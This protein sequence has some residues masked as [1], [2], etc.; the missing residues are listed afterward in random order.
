MWGGVCVLVHDDGVNFGIL[1]KKNEEIGKF[2]LAFD[3][4]ETKFDLKQLIAQVEEG[5]LEQPD[6]IK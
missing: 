4:S 6:L 3:K 1:V 5:N 2:S